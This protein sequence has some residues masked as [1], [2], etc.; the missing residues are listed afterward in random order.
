M[1]TQTKEAASCEL[2]LV[3]QPEEISV[4]TRDWDVAVH[5]ANAL[6]GQIIHAG[7]EIERIERQRWMTAVALGALL[8]RMKDASAHGQWSK[9]FSSNSAHVQNLV[10]TQNTAGRY[11]KLYKEVLKR[12]KRI[13]DDSVDVALIE[14]GNR[15]AKTYAEIAKLSDADTLRQAYVD[16]NVIRDRSTSAVSTQFTGSG[17]PAGR[18]K[19]DTLESTDPEA[20]AEEARQ[21]ATYASSEIIREL[22]TFVDQG[23]HALLATSDMNALESALRHATREL[24]TV[25]TKQENTPLAME[26]PDL[27]Q[28][29]VSNISVFN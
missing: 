21:L 1:K 7:D 16:F 8:T 11:M 22:M 14:A 13:K 9:I 29:D 10:F 17:N 6:H 27:S 3:D 23:R 28:I 4:T 19:K 26:A 2:M 15:D 18:P 20:E 24:H 5:K 25:R 12:A